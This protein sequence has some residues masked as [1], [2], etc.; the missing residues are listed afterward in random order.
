MSKFFYKL[1]LFIALFLNASAN[2]NANEAQKNYLTEGSEQKAIFFQ[3]PASEIMHEIIDLHS[4]IFSV[5]MVVFVLCCGLLLYILFR[6][7]EKRN[8]KP[9]TFTHNT[10]VEIL[11]TGIPLLIVSVL[12]FYNIQVLQKEEAQ[13]YQD[14]EMTIKIVGHQW[15]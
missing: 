10:T 8:P 3:E 14:M 6:F 5:M 12:A 13:E 2:A 7:H 1:F 15:Y 11:W 9:Q 4:I